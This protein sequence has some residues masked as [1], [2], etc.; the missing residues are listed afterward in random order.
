MTK[1]TNSPSINQIIT[2]PTKPWTYY[3]SKESG[4]WNEA[5]KI[6]TSK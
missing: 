3:S 1:K 6:N 4:I 2:E 5:L